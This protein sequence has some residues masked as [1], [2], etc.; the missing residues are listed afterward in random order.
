MKKFLN[1]R[2]SAELWEKHLEQFEWTDTLLTELE[3]KAV[4]NILIEY[5]DLPAT[6]RKDNEI[7][8]EI[9]KN[10]YQKMKRLFAARTYRCQST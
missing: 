7:N 6:N 2:D 10:S 3:R 4:E 1:P 8:G 9:E 5:H